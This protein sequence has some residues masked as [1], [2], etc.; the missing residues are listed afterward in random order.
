MV[1]FPLEELDWFID[2]IEP[3]KCC[4]PIEIPKAPEK[5]TTYFAMDVTGTPFS[6][7]VRMSLIK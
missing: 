7:L 5:E 1:F 2:L 6:R 4:F 3:K